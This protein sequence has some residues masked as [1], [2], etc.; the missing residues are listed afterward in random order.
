ME[1]GFSHGVRGRG[2]KFCYQ[3][4]V[5]HNT[6]RIF[7][8]SMARE[9][10]VIDALKTFIARIGA[11]PRLHSDNAQAETSDAI[12]RV[13]NDYGI[14]PTHT[15][16][17]HPAQDGRAESAIKLVKTRMEMM[18]TLYDCPASNWPYTLQ[19]VA[20]VLNHTARL[21]DWSRVFGER[22]K[23]RSSVQPVKHQTLPI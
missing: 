5:G 23:R 16:P 22:G 13:C 10:E 9:S 18:H 7:I 3:I 12:K 1:T 2:G 15:E 14:N 17:H 4:F 21:P 6:G 19:H 8:Y 20:Y 11:P